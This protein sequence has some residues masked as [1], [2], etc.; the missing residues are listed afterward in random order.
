MEVRKRPV[1]EKEIEVVEPE[2]AEGPLAGGDDVLGRVPVVPY[3]RGDP[4]ILAC[5]PAADDGLQSGADLRLVAVDGG[6]I[7]MPITD[8]RRAFDRGGDI[9]AVDAVG[10]ERA[11]SDRR[12]RRARV[13]APLRDRRRV[14]RF[15][16]GAGHCVHAFSETLGASRMGPRPLPSP[17]GLSAAVGLPEGEGR[18]LPP[19]GE[20][21][22]PGLDP[23]VARSAG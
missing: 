4:E 9:R 10:A 5:D 6:A 12:H 14:D 13:E 19:Q 11:K 1:H 7:E 8:R 2:I 22:A 18:A 21:P 20:E 3:F 17:R 15:D 16:G 23:G